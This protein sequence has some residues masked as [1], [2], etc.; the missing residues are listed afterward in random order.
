MSKPVSRGEPFARPPSPTT[1]RRSARSSMSRQRRHVIECGSMRSLFPCRRCASSIAASR[2]FAAPIA[3]MSPVKWR[4]TS[5]GGTIWAR[6]PPVP[7]PLIPKT[8][9]SEGSRRQRS[10]RSPIQQSASTSEIAVVVLPS[11]AFVGVTAVTQTS[12]PSAAAREAVECGQLDLRRVPAVVLDVVGHRGRARPRCR[13]S[14][15]ARFPLRVAMSAASSRARGRAIRI[16][17]GTSLRKSR[18]NSAAQPH[19]ARRLAA[20][21]GRRSG[22]LTAEQSRNHHK[23]RRKT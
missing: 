9:P 13:R 19:R 15:E 6:P 7:P 4:F 2:L 3:W 20:D 11:P 22:G 17:T 21:G 18:T 16:R 1:I 14:V 5:S 10:A 12:L 8:G 23:D